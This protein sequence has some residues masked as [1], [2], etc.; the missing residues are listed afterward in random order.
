MAQLCIKKLWTQFNPDTIEKTIRQ[1]WTKIH[2]TIMYKISMWQKWTIIHLTKN[3]QKSIWQSCTKIHPTIMYKISIWQKMDKNPSDK[4][5]TKTHLTK[6]GQKPI[7]QSW[8]N[9]VQFMALCY[10]RKFDQNRFFK[11]TA[12]KEVSIVVKT[13]GSILQNFISAGNFSDKFLS[14][15][16]GQIFI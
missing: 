6:N 11:S 12:T 5:W 3:G 9:I 2:P 4:K 13:Q 14:Q 7:W 8:T 16:F 10:V 1:S 15:D